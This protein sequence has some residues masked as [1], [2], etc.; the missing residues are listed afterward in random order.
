M[1]SFIE[2][3]D[4]LPKIKD[5]RL[6]QL[7]S[8]STTILDV[9][10]STAIQV[11]KD[12]LHSRYDVDTIFSKTTTQRDQQVVRWI[13]N[14]VLYY[15]CERLPDKLIPEHIV[16][17]YDDTIEMLK[18]LEDG[19]RSSQLPRITNNDNEPVTKF[20]WGGNEKRTH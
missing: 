16:T 1:S 3:D 11:V 9:A 7:T 10:E 13:C 15:I 14:L 5:K 19:K 18:N 6:T 17:N 20:R 2:R 8:N 12:A 4:Y